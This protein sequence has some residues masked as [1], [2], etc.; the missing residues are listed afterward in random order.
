MSTVAIEPIKL[1]KKK[2]ESIVH[3]AEKSAKAVNLIYVSDTDPGI[4]RVKK[5]D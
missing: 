3:D 4:T 2:I 1:S 5:G